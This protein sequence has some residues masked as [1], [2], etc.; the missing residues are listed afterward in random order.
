MTTSKI[1]PDMLAVMAAAAEH[2]DNATDFDA[3]PMLTAV[4]AMTEL[5]EAVRADL[6]NVSSHG[7]YERRKRIRAA[8]AAVGGAA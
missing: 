7:I 6:D 1:S 4:D 5:V 3:G 2:L 8:L